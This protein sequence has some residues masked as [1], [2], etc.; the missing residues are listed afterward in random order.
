MNDFARRL[1]EAKRTLGVDAVIGSIAGLEKRIKEAT[2]R[3]S[4]FEKTRAALSLAERTKS[5]A[6]KINRSDAQTHLAM[7]TA[8]ACLEPCLHLAREVEVTRMEV[9][10]LMNRSNE[11]SSLYELV[12][13]REKA[14]INLA[15]E[16]T[17]QRP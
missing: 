11:P 6:A 12:A 17:L 8:T 10:S 5:L 13:L 3:A 14:K 7:S 9:E 16:P 1:A 4:A 2:E 15:G